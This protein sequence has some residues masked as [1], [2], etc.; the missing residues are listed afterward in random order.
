MMEGEKMEENI[1]SGNVDDYSTTDTDDIK[2]DQAGGG[3]VAASGPPGD[4][5]NNLPSTLKMEENKKMMKQ[6]KLA[7]NGDDDDIDDDKMDT[8]A[9][10]KRKISQ[11]PKARC[12]PDWFRQKDENGNEVSFYLRPVANDVRK[13]FC[14]V[15]NTEFK[16]SSR[17]WAAISDHLKSQKHM[18]A[19]HIA[20]ST[21][22]VGAYFMKNAASSE[23]TST[24]FYYSQHV[25]A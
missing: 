19:I 24:A 8:P 16:I 10:K 13:V 14:S 17:G 20:K 6:E 18:S 22:S 9:R 4:A 11:A 15:D 1:G 7:V 5:V 21:N 3:S 2:A 12:L 25:M 23:R